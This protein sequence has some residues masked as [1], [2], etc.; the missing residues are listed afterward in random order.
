VILRN[1]AGRTLVRP[2]IV[3]DAT[4]GGTVA[5]LAEC[6]PLGTSTEACRPAPLVF[7][8]AGIDAGAFLAQ[9]AAAAEMLAAPTHPAIAAD[10]AA[11]AAGLQEQGRVLAV[12]D[13]GAAQIRAAVTA[14]RMI[15]SAGVTIAQTSAPRRDVVVRVDRPEGVDPARIDRAAGIE[16]C[17]GFLRVALPGFGQAVISAVHPGVP[18]PMV[19][20]V[21]GDRVLGQ[22]GA[23][24]GSGGADVVARGCHGARGADHSG[25]GTFGIPFGCMLPQG[26][27]NLLVIGG[28]LS[29]HPSMAEDT[30]ATG[31]RLALGEAAGTAAALTAGPTAD[32]RRIDLPGLRRSLRQQGALLEAVG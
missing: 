24:A 17:A 4:E 19:R 2:K 9:L 26:C 3:I 1:K 18:V 22:S 16:T 31:T 6:P 29:A 32:L 8:M 5:A 25:D 13:P 12:L 15:A 20:P 14:G 21:L 7:R 10:R 28:G 23:A 27:D 30:A 11:A